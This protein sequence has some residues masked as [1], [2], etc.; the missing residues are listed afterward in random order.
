MPYRIVEFLS[1][2]HNV[3][4]YLHDPTRSEQAERYAPAYQPTSRMVADMQNVLEGNPLWSSL[5]SHASDPDV[6]TARLVLRWP[7][8]TPGLRMFVH[9]P[10]AAVIGPRTIYFTN[11]DSEAP[12]RIRADDP[13]YALMSWPVLFPNGRQLKC[14]PHGVAED[15]PQDRFCWGPLEEGPPTEG[16]DFYP[17]L[18]HLSHVTLAIAYQPER[19]WQR[20]VKGAAAGFA[21][22][23]ADPLPPRF[24]MV[25]TVSPYAPEE[26]IYRP[27]SR[28]ELAGRVGEEYLLDRYLT[29]LDAR[30]H[31]LCA[32]QRQ[33][34]G[35][36]MTPSE[37][38]EYEALEQEE[39]DSAHE[40][41]RSAKRITSLPS[42][43]PGTPQHHRMVASK[44]IYVAHKTQRPLGFLTQTL[45]PKWPEIQTRLACFPGAHP[46][47]GYD[48]NWNVPGTERRQE[49][50]DRPALH[51]DVFEGKRRAME[52]VLR[53]GTLFRNLGRPK[54]NGTVVLPSAKG[55]AV[56]VDSYRFP[57]A[58]AGGGHLMGARENQRNGFEHMHYLWA[59][60]ERPSGATLDCNPGDPM[61][62]VDDLVCARVPDRDVLRQFK[63]LLPCAEARKLPGVCLP[64]K[65]CVAIANFNALTEIPSQKKSFVYETFRYLDGVA[66]TTLVAH[67]DLVH[68]F[69]PYFA[70]PNRLLYEL[71][72][73]SSGEGQ[74]LIGCDVS[75]HGHSSLTEGTFAT[76]LCR[77][78]PPLSAKGGV[79]V[80]DASTVGGMHFKV[81]LADGTTHDVE[82]VCLQWRETGRPPF[83]YS[84]GVYPASRK[85][86]GRMVH[87]HPRGPSVAPKQCCSSKGPSTCT[88]YFPKEVVSQTQ[89][90]VHGFVE[91]RRFPCDIMIV[92]YNA[93]ALIKG[94]SHINF[95]IVGSA[96]GSLKYL[97]KLVLYTYKPH[98]TN[99]AQVVQDGHE[100]VGTQDE[101]DRTHNRR[102]PRDQVG[103]W[104][105]VMEFCSPYALRAHHVRPLFVMSPNVV[106]IRYVPSDSARFLVV[107]RVDLLLWS[108]FRCR[109]HG[110]RDVDS[111][112]SENDQYGISQWELY[113]SRPRLPELACVTVEEF[114][115][116]WTSRITP[117]KP[118]SDVDRRC[119]D[120]Y[121]NYNSKSRTVY[122]GRSPSEH[123]EPGTRTGNLPIWVAPRFYWRVKRGFDE[124]AV[125]PPPSSEANEALSDDS[126]DV[127][128]RLEHDE[129]FSS[130]SSSDETNGH[131]SEGGGGGEHGVERQVGD[132]NHETNVDGS[133]DDGRD[134]GLE[135]PI[136]EDSGNGSSGEMDDDDERRDWRDWRVTDSDEMDEMH[137]DESEAGEDGVERQDV[138]RE[139]SSDDDVDEQDHRAHVQ[140]ARRATFKDDCHYRLSRIP[141]KCQH[142]FFMRKLAHHRSA[143]SFTDLLTDNNGVVHATAQDAC[144]ELGYLDEE[145][146]A[147]HLMRHQMDSGYATP[148]MLRSLFT[149]LVVA[150]HGVDDL[151]EDPGLLKAMCEPS[152]C[153]DDLLADLGCRLSS[154]GWN[155]RQCVKDCHHPVWTL[156]DLERTLGRLPARHV[157]ARR[158][159]SDEALALDE[160]QRRVVYWALT[161]ELRAPGV[162]IPDVRRVDFIAPMQV[163]VG[164]L[165]AGQGTGKSRVF[166]RTIAE[167][168]ARAC[169]VVPTATTN[170]AATAFEG[171]MTL[172]SLVG[173]GIDPDS[174]GNTV[175]ELEAAGGSVTAQRDELLASD[176]CAVVLIDEGL[177]A[178]SKLVEAI[179]AFFIRRRYRFRVLINGDPSQL[180]PVVVNGTPAEIVA[181]SLMSSW[182]WRR[183]D[184]HFT[185]RT[186]YRA[187]RD[188]PWAAFLEGLATNS[189]ASVA[190]HAFNNAAEH[191]AAVAMPLIPNRHVFIH[192][193][194]QTYGTELVYRAISALFGRTS[195]K[196]LDLNFD[197]KTD[198]RQILCATN[199]QCTFWND[200]I[201][202]MKE[203]DGAHINE[204]VAQNDAKIK[205]QDDIDM[206]SYDLALEALQDE[207]D[208]FDHADHQV[209]PSRLRLSVGDRVIL[210]VRGSRCAIVGQAPI[211]TLILVFVFMQPP[212]TR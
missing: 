94:D 210:P 20:G 5:V 16:A 52:A 12:C 54:W 158:L 151:L 186:Q 66:E 212:H 59:P 99:A 175:V 10:A 11:V 165:A 182:V 33:L 164:V 89:M 169:F 142:A 63:W 139:S 41:G 180:P 76:V 161:G 38:A 135:Q 124:G 71:I 53:S 120:R 69:G 95:E 13:R 25:P 148:A 150:K 193:S 122:V 28:V 152:W 19:C 116:D 138:G 123:R 102:L 48:E 137:H 67:P 202:A 149:Q 70:E 100:M 65:Q 115:K 127:E 154:V 208:M 26:R 81:R 29:R 9:Q 107:H 194:V 55:D 159:D 192:R 101:S 97:F 2:G 6:M 178:E 88:S 50:H 103:H 106:D 17:R 46:K 110:P 130:S 156:S 60:S 3:Q 140:E 163:E 47:S 121:E 31:V 62:W 90:G 117:L 185:L 22:Q 35:R 134:D 162:P 166:L 85:P 80:V 190:D 87:K 167:L 145:A 79:S 72:K 40:E 119:R 177:A 58:V 157:W 207:A 187:S 114:F 30:R 171:G 200:H 184:A 1:E 196:K 36:T 73:L 132:S 74:D 199:T 143:Y 15:W 49:P 7:G 174:D 91:Y 82:R 56:E 206:Q 34:R 204:Y 64:L 125:G 93:W 77:V 109:I 8:N 118:L 201:T 83:H 68:D 183:A 96:A 181:R 188:P 42:T 141:F 51:C 112:W 209:P 191:A 39:A 146:E 153:K 160:P 144:R 75:V 168:G 27:M 173:L 45:N 37:I 57:L 111:F 205:G 203:R 113:L 197:P 136:G 147:L 14:Q 172:H 24:V 189:C 211:P 131:E 198:A 32:I 4:A 61:P 84:V 155:I 104:Y 176:Q 98:E 44:A 92:G 18:E 195:D 23:P 108:P 133:G 86:Q 105:Q 21:Y 179:I 128:S 129:G 78:D 43:E 126:M 170:L